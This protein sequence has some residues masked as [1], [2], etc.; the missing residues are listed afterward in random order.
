MRG[1]CD[2]RVQARNC[3]HNHELYV[4]CTHT[5]LFFEKLNPQE[6]EFMGMG[7]LLSLSL[8]CLSLFVAHSS[9]S[10]NALTQNIL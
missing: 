4:V 3:L 7:F 9:L 6:H 8:S 10:M 5:K 1:V 2:A